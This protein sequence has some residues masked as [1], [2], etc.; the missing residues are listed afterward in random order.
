MSLV[1]SL[2]ISEKS[3]SLS[4]LFSYHKEVEDIQKSSPLPSCLQAEQKSFLRPFPDVLR[5]TTFS[6]SVATAGLFPW[7][8]WLPSSK[9]AKLGTS[10][11]MQPGSQVLIQAERHLSLGWSGTEAN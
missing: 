4:F 11:Q 8:Q 9:E 3:L 6:I 7:S 10:L 5:S 1:L 2:C